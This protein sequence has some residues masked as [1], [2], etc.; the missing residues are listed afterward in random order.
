MTPV[1]EELEGKYGWQLNVV[2]A[3]VDQQ[4]G[5]DLAKK[6][7]IIGYPTVLLLDSNGEKVGVLRGVVPLPSLEKALAGLLQEEP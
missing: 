7:G 3:E 5:K 1:V 2:Y 6:H 4:Q